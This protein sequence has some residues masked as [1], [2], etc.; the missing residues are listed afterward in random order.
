MLA[1]QGT[2]LCLHMTITVICAIGALLVRT[3]VT[4]VVR[5][6]LHYTAAGDNF[7]VSQY[8]FPVFEMYTES[9]PVVLCY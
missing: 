8:L 1:V 9:L 2:G 7:S 3:T 5:I 6:E 4:T